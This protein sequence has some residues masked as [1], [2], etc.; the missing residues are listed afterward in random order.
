MERE[1]L[2]CGPVSG[3]VTV[4]VLG[5]VPHTSGNELIVLPFDTLTCEFCMR[6]TVVPTSQKRRVFFITNA[7]RWPFSRD[8]TVASAGNR[9][10][11]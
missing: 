3:V 4:T 10:A 2:Q 8:I 11:T 6:D 7:E 9:T 5:T 1:S